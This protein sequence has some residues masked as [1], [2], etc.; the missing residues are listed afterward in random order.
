MPDEKPTKGEI[1]LALLSL[2]PPAIRASVLEEQAFRQCFDLAVDVVIRLDPSGV[3]LDRSKLFSAVRKLLTANASNVE[4]TSRD[5]LRWTVAFSNDKESILLI[6]EGAEIAL[7]D[8]SCLS[9]DSARRLAWFDREVKRFALN[10]RSTD[11]WREILSARPVEDEEVDPLLSEL[12]LTPLY[13]AGSIANQLRS[14]TISMPSLVPSDIRYYDR[15]V[16]ELNGQMDLKD[17]VAT[18]ATARIWEPIQ[19]QPFHGLKR[20]FLLSS[21]P[22]I[23]QRVALNEVPRE[24]VLRFYKWLDESGD[25][26]SQLGGVECGLAHLE[27]FPELEGNLVKM[28]QGFL[29]DDP[30]DMEGRLKLLCG[31]IVMVEGELARIGIVRRR[32]PFWRRLA[33]IAH[34]SAIE[35]EIIAAGIPPSTFSE[36]A[37]Q[38][39]GQ[40]YYMQSFIDLRSEP[41]WLPDFVLPDQLKMEFIGRVAGAAHLNASKI[42]T[43]ELKA[44]LLEKNSGGI[45]SRLNFPFAFLPGPLEGGVES[46]TEMPANI[47]SELRRGLEAEELT[48]KSFA[49][50]VNSALIFRIGPQLARLA[51]QALRRARHQLRQVRAQDETFALLSGLGTVAAVT[52]SS[53]LAE[54]VRIFVRLVRRRP[55]IDIAPEDAMRIA[56]ITAAAYSDKGKWCSFVGDWLTELAFEDM[57][58]EKAVIL[59]RHILVLCQLEP[60]LWETCARAEAACMAFAASQAA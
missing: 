44:L 22:S 45:Q 5:G 47:E 18:T 3:N 34:A 57:A 46:I 55:G 56:M 52:R 13:V 37:M 31:L 14:E 41:R 58:R 19:Q 21:H 16:G 60:H 2:F 35:R 49:S 12:R 38:S 15:L 43:G 40:L 59:R 27:A 4:V 29:A 39:R 42:Q 1:G 24:D 6:R 50:L 9:P 8:F 11:K 32:P 51:A 7:P 53:E 17:F 25:R 36:C 30:E 20:A 28:V 10:D 54:E 23:V 33:A 26:I 48:P